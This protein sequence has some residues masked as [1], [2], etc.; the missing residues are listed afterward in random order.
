MGT[1]DIHQI[2]EGNSLEKYME[3]V[4]LA[5]YQDVNNSYGT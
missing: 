4:P 5:N 3:W 1:G 2:R